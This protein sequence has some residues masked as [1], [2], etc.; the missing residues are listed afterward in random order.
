MLYWALVLDHNTEQQESIFFHRQ[1]LFYL[2]SK[3]AKW[4]ASFGVSSLCLDWRLEASRESRV[5]KR[6]Q[7]WLGLE[8]HY[9]L[10]DF[11]PLPL[12]WWNF[13]PLAVDIWRHPLKAKFLQWSHTAPVRSHPTKQKLKHFHG[14]P[15]QCIC[16]YAWKEAYHDN[17]DE[18]TEQVSSLNLELD[19]RTFECR[20][21]PGLGY[22]ENWNSDSRSSSC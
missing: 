17:D 1:I 6:W 9:T 22:E 3:L 14:W 10:G 16:D 11:G 4:R 18:T 19:T 21:K 8:K 13:F 2:K 5:V 20:E 7:S 15:V 12:S